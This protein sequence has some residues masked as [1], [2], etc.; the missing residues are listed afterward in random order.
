MKKNGLGRGMD[1]LMRADNVTLEPLKTETDIDREYIHEL[2]ITLIDVNKDQPRKTFHQETIQALADSIRANGMLQPITV[3]AVGDRYEII[4]GERRYRAC[5]LLKMETVPAIIKELSPR[6]VCELA[7][8]ENLQR[9][10]L[11]PMEE[12][13]ALQSLMLEFTLTQQEVADRIGTSRPAI[14]NALRLLKLPK[15][16]Q[17]MLASGAL[18]A[19][20][21]RTLAVVEDEKLACTLAEAAA[22]GE[23]S[24]RQLEQQVKLALTEKKPAKVKARAPEFGQLEEQMRLR[25]GTRVA[26]NGS[27][28]KGK[29]EIEYFSRDD[30]ERLY[31][32]L[33]DN[34][35]L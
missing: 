14:A 5:R 12:A 16:V 6:Q 3:H 22:K 24:V 33:S 10:D 34:A 23:W 17:D 29:I 13:A 32:I 4:A 15:P 1:A 7:L 20:H 35:E 9:E 30:L 11:N 8:I 19:G 18:S 25:L 2:P 21:G 27:E 31:A 28:K 26:I